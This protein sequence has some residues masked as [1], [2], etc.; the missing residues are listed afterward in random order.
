MF[1]TFRYNL[2][3]TIMDALNGRRIR[4]IEMKDDPNPVESGALGTICN[5]GG[6][7]I[8][9]DWDNGRGLGLV[10]GEDKYELL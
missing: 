4:L 10:E 5:I 7:V 8:N 9:V 3:T 6:G 2:K 1:R